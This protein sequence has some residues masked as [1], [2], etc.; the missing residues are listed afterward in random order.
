MSQQADHNSMIMAN[1]NLPVR[2][3]IAQMETILFKEKSFSEEKS[4]GSP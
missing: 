3:W 2:I 1:F 4:K